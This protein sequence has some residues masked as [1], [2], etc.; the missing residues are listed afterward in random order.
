MT[1]NKKPNLRTNNKKYKQIRELKTARFTTTQDQKKVKRVNNIFNYPTISPSSWFYCIENGCIC[2][3]E[4]ITKKDAEQLN[5][6]KDG[7]YV[8]ETIGWICLQKHGEPY[9]KKFQYFTFTL[10]NAAVIA[11]QIEVTQ[12][13]S[14]ESVVNIRPATMEEGM[15]VTTILE[16]VRPNKVIK[17]S[18]SEAWDLV[19]MEF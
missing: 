6:S 7:I 1:K 17:L 8:I 4:P 9:H 3:E 10:A 14:A 5:T 11:T 2:Y 19:E 13:E 18:S 12:R 15:I 16:S